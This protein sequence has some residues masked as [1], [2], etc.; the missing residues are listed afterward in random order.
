MDKIF[1]LLFLLIACNSQAQQ[2]GLRV[3]YNFLHARSNVN[4]TSWTGSEGLTEVFPHDEK[5]TKKEKNRRLF[6]HPFW[7]ISVIKSINS[8]HS[9]SIGYLNLWGY[10][11][12]S[13]EAKPKNNYGSLKWSIEEGQ[14]MPAI[15]LNYIYTYYNRNATD[16]N[17]STIQLIAGILLN[18]RGKE[19][20]TFST[21]G[22]LYS[23]FATNNTPTDT[24]FIYRKNLG[25]KRPMPP[26]PYLNAGVNGCLRLGKRFRLGIELMGYLGYS[27][28][29]IHQFEGKT[30]DAEFT[31]NVKL[32]PYFF[33]SGFYLQYR[34]K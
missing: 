20:E 26:T 34:L 27:S 12:H 3:A 17:T 4:V 5:L 10:V 8:K 22:T 9:F 31:Y 24:V 33:S 19:G 23:V 6:K 25:A 30:Q 14:D 7:E 28:L 1:V 11:S 16:I 21:G 2:W 15:R 13:I 32:K 29:F 18:F